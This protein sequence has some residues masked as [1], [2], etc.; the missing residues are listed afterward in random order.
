[1]ERLL[2]ISITALKGN[3][4]LKPDRKQA[5]EIY[6]N[7]GNG[8]RAAS[9]GV[10]TDTTHEVA[11]VRFVYDHNGQTHDETVLLRWKQSNLNN[12]G[13]YYFSCPVTGRSCRKL[14]F[15]GGRFVSRFAFRA[16]YESQTVG[17]SERNNVYY[18]LAKFCE[19]EQLAEQ[20]YRKETYNGKPTPYGRKLERYDN[21]AERLAAIL[22]QARNDAVNTIQRKIAATPQE[23][24]K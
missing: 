23:T 11:T 4:L 18:Q 17:P 13:F 8:T 19:Y 1:M 24:P 22:T 6:W 15:V 20:P 5:G 3:G 12:G 7:H 10:I 14:Y 2:A 9:M 21:N 16:L